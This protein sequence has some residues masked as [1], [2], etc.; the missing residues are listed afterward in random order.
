MAYLNAI[1]YVISAEIIY[2]DD[3]DSSVTAILEHSPYEYEDGVTEAID[4]CDKLLRR[5]A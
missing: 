5:K 2:L 4:D 3:D 1:G